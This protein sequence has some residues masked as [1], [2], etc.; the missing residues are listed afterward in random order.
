MIAPRSIGGR[1]EADGQ[2]PLPVDVEGDRAAP[3]DAARAPLRVDVV[4]HLL[5]RRALRGDRLQADLPVAADL[6]LVAADEDRS[7][8]VLRRQEQQT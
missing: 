7:R 5:R 3:E 2:A 6:L 8:P 1:L 4:E